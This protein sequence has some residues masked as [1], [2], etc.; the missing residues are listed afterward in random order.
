MAVPAVD[1]IVDGWLTPALVKIPDEDLAAYLAFAGSRFG[2][3][4]YVALSESYDLQAGEWYAQTFKLFQDNI[5]PAALAAGAPGRDALLAD[6]RYA[7][8]NVG[9]P[10]AAADAMGKLLQA[11]RLDPRN[12]EIQMLLGEAAIKTAPPMPLTPDQLR[13]VIDTPNYAQAE[14]YLSKAIELAPG[15][16]DA[17]MLLGRLRYLQG[18]NEDA[19]QSYTRAREIESE[20]PNIDLYLGDLAFVANEYDKASRYYKLAVS[21]P[22]RRAYVHVTALAHLLM[23]LRKSTQLTEYPRVAEAYLAQ[24]PDAWNFRLDYADHLLSVDTR[25]D[26][27]L[28][29]IEPIP[30]AWLP[31]RK[32]PALSAA[33]VRKAVEFV[34][35][36][37]EPREQSMRLMQRTIGLNPDQDTLAEAMCRGDATSKLTRRTLDVSKNQKAL[38]TALVICGLRWQRHDIVRVMTLRADIP[39]LS[40]SHPDLGGDTPLCYAAATKN[41]QGFSALVEIRVSPTPKCSDGNTVAER[42]LQMSFGRDPTIAQ[43]RNMMKQFYKRS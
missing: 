31:A 32:V 14:T 1:S 9:T 15:Q 16:V 33:L 21:K 2:G 36:A 23:A 35:N 19:L 30:D 13:V 5:P 18:R 20:H 11:D 40:R 8:W 6:A 22:E 42:L 34:D 24:H 4:Y 27:V 3:D 26:K 12:A 37:G 28:A 17:H 43:M 39:R 25:A 10:A 29:I 7:L 38:A 41:L